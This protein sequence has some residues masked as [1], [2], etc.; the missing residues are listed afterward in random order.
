MGLHAPRRGKSVRQRSGEM[1]LTIALSGSSRSSSRAVCRSRGC[2]SGFCEDGQR[3]APKAHQLWEH[4]FRAHTCVRACVLLCDCVRTHEWMRARA[5]GGCVFGARR[6]HIF[7]LVPALKATDK[8]RE[9]PNQP[10]ASRLD[11]AANASAAEEA[12]SATVAAAI[13]R[14]TPHPRAARLSRHRNRVDTFG[15]RYSC[16]HSR[17]R[18]EKYGQPTLIA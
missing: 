10:Q 8:R 13:R 4:Q 6:S 17:R 11:G 15:R 1:R 2:R 16:R 5:R 7:D 12:V 9:W 14:A 3:N 18:C